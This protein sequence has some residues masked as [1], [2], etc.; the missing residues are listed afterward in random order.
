MNDFKIRS[1]MLFKDVTKLMGERPSFEVNFSR[2][3]YV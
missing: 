3:V 2:R 1:G